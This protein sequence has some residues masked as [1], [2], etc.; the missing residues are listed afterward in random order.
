LGA[1]GDLGEPGRV[2][3]GVDI[4]FAAIEKGRRERGELV[5]ESSLALVLFVAARNAALDRDIVRIGLR[6][7]ALDTGYARLEGLTFAMLL[8][9]LAV[10][11]ARDRED[12][13]ALFAAEPHAWSWRY[14]R[15]GSL[16][17]ARQPS[18]TRLRTPPRRHLP[19]GPPPSHRPRS[20][21]DDLQPWDRR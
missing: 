12:Y 19:E 5:D 21:I 2:R 18:D 20:E 6:E 15:H 13:V 7:R 11:T 16:K 3:S 8:V 9:D 4:G 10:L 1:L 14:A 17:E